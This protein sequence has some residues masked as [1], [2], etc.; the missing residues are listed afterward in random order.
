MNDY[1]ITGLMIGLATISPF[2]LMLVITVY[3]IAKGE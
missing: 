3:Q 2:F 1:Q